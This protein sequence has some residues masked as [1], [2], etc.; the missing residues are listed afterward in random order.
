M[1]STRSAGGVVVGPHGKIVVVNQR[2][3]SWSLPKG[4]IEEGE[5]SLEAAKREI[6]EE[7]GIEDLQLVDELG[8]YERW[9]L[10]LGGGDD[11]AEKKIITLFLFTTDSEALAPVDP[12]NPEARW[13]ALDEVGSLL[14][15]AR[16]G[17]FF[18][19]IR[20][21]V[22]PLVEARSRR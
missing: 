10:S 18:D 21:S 8:T 4:H 7:T 2:G 17:E 14:T 9:K 16:D 6:W 13:V 15:H 11:P 5:T 3:D 19:S 1:R 22:R 20:G 12:K